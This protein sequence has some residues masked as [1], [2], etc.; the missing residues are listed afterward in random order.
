MKLEEL[1]QKISRY[2]FLEKEIAEWGVESDG[3]YLLYR[4]YNENR[5]VVD[6][7]TGDKIVMEYIKSLKNEREVLKVALGLD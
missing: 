3:Q 2:S 4:M 6:K 1:K 5:I 7:N